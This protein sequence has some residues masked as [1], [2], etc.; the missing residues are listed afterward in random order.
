VSFYFR[1]WKED[2]SREGGGHAGKP[3]Q[4]RPCAWK[5]FYRLDF[6]VSF[7]V[8]QKRKRKDGFIKISLLTSITGENPDLLAT[9]RIADIN[10]QQMIRRCK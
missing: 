10:N 8:K 1:N 5:V 4:R 9:G 7:L 2:R 3:G 6:F